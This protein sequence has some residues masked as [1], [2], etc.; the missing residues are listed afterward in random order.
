MQGIMECAYCIQN[1]KIVALPVPEI[2]GGIQKNLGSPRI[3]P[4]SLFSKIFNGLL[5]GWTLWMLRPN[6]RVPEI[7]AIR[8]WVGVANPQSWGRGGHRESGMAPWVPIRPP[9]H[10]NFSSIFTRFRDVAACAPAHHILPYPSS[11]VSSKFLHVHLE[12][13]V[14]PLGYEERRC[15]ANGPCNY[16]FQDFQPIWSW[17]TNV[18]DRRIDGQTDDMRSQDRALDYSAS[19]FK[20][21]SNLKLQSRPS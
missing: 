11:I 9:I 15:W 19:R 6:L 3:R 8:V 7:I 18:T 4:R 1:L 2:I 20:R 10:S 12:V 13:G 14:W 16:S 17:S 5:F 21:K